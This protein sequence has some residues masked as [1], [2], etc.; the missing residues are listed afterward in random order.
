MSFIDP[1]QL[2]I[3][4]LTTQANK[5]RLDENPP[6]LPFDVQDPVFQK[7][8]LDGAKRTATA[9]DYYKDIIQLSFFH[10]GTDVKQHFMFCDTM[11]ALPEAPENVSVFNV[12]ANLVQASSN[13]LMGMFQETDTGISLGAP[14]LTGWKVQTD[15]WPIIANKS[16]AYN[17]WV[18]SALKTNPLKRFSTIDCLLDVSNVYSQGINMSMRKLPF[19]GD[20]L[21]YWGYQDIEYPTP[22]KV[23]DLVCTD[24]VAAAKQIEPYLEALHDVMLRYCNCVVSIPPEQ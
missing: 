19:V 3:V 17:M 7:E 24:P 20:A 21:R 6:R 12:E 8:L 5:E 23:R 13:Y 18:P 9:Y 15:I 16:M 14:I 10:I 11:G 4:Y 22:D 1:D 2:L